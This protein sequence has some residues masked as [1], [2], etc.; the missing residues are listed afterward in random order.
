MSGGRCSGNAEIQGG[1]RPSVLVAVLVPTGTGPV[2]RG[3]RRIQICRP[4][5]SRGS[6][7]TQ[8]VG[9]GAQEATCSA[10][11]PAS[12][13]QDLPRRAAIPAVRGSEIGVDFSAVRPGLEAWIQPRPRH[14]AAPNGQ[15]PLGA[16]PEPSRP[17][18][19]RTM[20]D[21]TDAG[22]NRGG[23]ANL[24]PSRELP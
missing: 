17:L 13:S 6:Q 19:E 22:T 15:A 18:S 7:K 11:R 5:G 4:R 1:R 9:R 23:H 16:W 10:A 12:S 14:D 2:P 21:D 8:V 24:E 20:K 3:K